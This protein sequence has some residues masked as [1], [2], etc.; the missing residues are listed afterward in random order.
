MTC[1]DVLN[2]IE[3]VIAGDEAATPE[4]RT[5][6]EG[7]VRCAAALATARQIEEALAARPVPAAPAGFG[8]A[9]AAR[10]RQDRWRSEEHVDRV[11]NVALVLGIL[12]VV[13]G[14]AALFNVGALAS[15]VA[16]GLAILNRATGELIVRAAPAVRT[17]VIAIGF[18]ATALLVW[19]WAERRLSL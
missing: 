7:C 17:Y 1:H 12:L 14:V 3:A 19:W 6:L 5:H 15:G 4:M 10:I 9:V 8:A 11:F 18:L 13:G 16:G 2:R